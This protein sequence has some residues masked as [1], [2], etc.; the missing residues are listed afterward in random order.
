MEKARDVL[1]GMKGKIPQLKHLEVG[2]DIVRSDRS[3]DIALVTKF[4]S[5]EELISYQA[6]P[7]HI[8]VSKYITSVKE[9]SVSVDFETHP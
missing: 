3:C 7:V 9:S 4:D 2:V 1:L 5:M 6:H 8:E